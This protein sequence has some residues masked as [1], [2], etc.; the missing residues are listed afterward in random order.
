MSDH[1][2]MEANYVYSRDY[3]TDSNERDPFND[4]SGPPLPGCSKSELSACF[5]TA[6][7][8]APSNRDERHKLNMYL[9]GD[10]PWHFQGNMRMQVHSAQPNANPR[11]TDPLTNLPADV[12]RN[13]G[14]K[15]NAYSSVDWRLSRDFK[16][17][18]RFK[19][20]PM[21]E[22]F[23]TFNSTNNVNTLSA[24]PLF[25]FNGFLRLGVGDPRQAQ[26]SVKFTF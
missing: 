19:L 12:P 9:T 21:V 25:D 2:Q 23:N 1:F 13:F 16:F 20:T 10:L 15:D 14:R 4:F 22:M 3:D 6:L 5:P 26:L 24:P 11:G 7:D 17:G 8:W 18:E